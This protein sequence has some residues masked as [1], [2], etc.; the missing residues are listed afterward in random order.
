MI[1]DHSA[2]APVKAI[3]DLRHAD[4]DLAHLHFDIPGAA[5]IWRRVVAELASAIRRFAS[6]AVDARPALGDIGRTAAPLAER[7]P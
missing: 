4:G 7:G 1:G 6:A 2:G 5:N 3:G